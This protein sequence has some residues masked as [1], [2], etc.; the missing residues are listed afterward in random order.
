MRYLRW[1]AAFGC[2]AAA[3]AIAGHPA[4]A[5]ACPMCKLSLINSPEGKHLAKAFNHGILFLLAMPYL[6]GVALAASI[7][8]MMRKQGARQSDEL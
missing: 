5:Q 1:A 4:F 7:W 6:L 3:V 8:S 2:L